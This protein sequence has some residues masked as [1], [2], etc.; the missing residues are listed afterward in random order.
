MSLR[1]QQIVLTKYLRTFNFAWS[2]TLEGIQL[3]VF[4][5]KLNLHIGTEPEVG[6]CVVN[7]SVDKAVLIA[8]IGLEK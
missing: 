2:A 3:T 5:Q 6:H 4:Q 1:V 7:D 8:I